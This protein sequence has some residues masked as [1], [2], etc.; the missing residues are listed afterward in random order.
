MSQML[1]KQLVLM[2]ILLIA[3]FFLCHHPTYYRKVSFYPIYW[4]TIVSLCF[5]FFPNPPV[6]HF[7]INCIIV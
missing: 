2:G 1:D 6:H 7:H 3:D 5:T 4:F